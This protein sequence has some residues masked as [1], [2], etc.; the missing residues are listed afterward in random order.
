M[1]EG[2]ASE[3]KEEEGERISMVSKKRGKLVLVSLRIYYS[4]T[5]TLF[6]VGEL[7]CRNESI[8]VATKNV[9]E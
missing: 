3:E 7:F 4:R 8:R 2:R 6:G 1:E 9:F 5:C